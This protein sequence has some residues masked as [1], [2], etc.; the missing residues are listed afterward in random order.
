MT[1]KQKLNC[2]EFKECGREPGGA[3]EEELGPCPAALEKRVDGFHGGKNG[4]RA[5]WAIAGTYCG[6]QVDG[7][8]AAKIKDCMNCDF[9][10]HVINEESEYKSAANYLRHVRLT[11]QN[12]AN[13]STSILRTVYRDAKRTAAESS[14][15]ESVYISFLIGFASF[16][17]NIRMLQ[18]SNRL[19]KDDL[20][21]ELWVIDSIAEKKKAKTA[22]RLFARTVLKAWRVQIKN[23]FSPLL[24]LGT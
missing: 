21:D 19:C 16:C 10:R 6:D 1:R 18:A 23:Y 13:G 8:Y 7:L 2:W 9:H 17:P 15:V 14:D 12:R 3:N 5:C 24:S 4:G 11:E 22:T 20:I